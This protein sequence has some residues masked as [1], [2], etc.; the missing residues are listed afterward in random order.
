[1]SF[2]P[3][4][5]ALTLVPASAILL[6]AS[7]GAAAMSTT[8]AKKLVA[9]AI[10]ATKSST[11]LTLIGYGKSEGKPVAFNLNVSPK[12][13]Y[14]ILSYGDVSTNLRRVGTNI[15]AKGTK[16]FLEQEG[17][18]ASVASQA[19]GKWFQIKSS[20]TSDYEGIDQNLTASGILVGLLPSKVT[21]AITA[22]KK[23]T[24][25]G[26][27]AEAISGTFSGEKGVLYVATHGKPYL[28]KVVQDSSKTDGGSITLSNFG[29][30]FRISTPSPL[31][32]G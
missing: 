15:Y 23:T 29:K 17:E 20:D 16:G 8:Q 25:G 32:N 26:Q 2:I 3:R 11:T 18:S 9:S 19:A 27:P 7:S 22:V 24:V 1:M 30:S 12:Y 5:A 6:G 14:G 13:A 31:I 10:T 21:G 28:L 4:L